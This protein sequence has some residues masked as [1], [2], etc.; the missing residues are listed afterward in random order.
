MLQANQDNVFEV[1]SERGRAWC[2]IRPQRV[3]PSRARHRLPIRD[4]TLKQALLSCVRFCHVAA[5][6]TLTY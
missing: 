6:V 1:A 2:L 3:V 4:A 5:K